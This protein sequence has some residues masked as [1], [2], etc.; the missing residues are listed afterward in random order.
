MRPPVPEPAPPASVRGGWLDPS[1][2]RRDLKGRL[3]GG[4]KPE[5]YDSLIGTWAEPGYRA[6]IPDDPG[7]VG[8]G[9]LTSSRWSWWRARTS[10]YATTVC[11]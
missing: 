6:D 9:G 8:G 2:V 5:D 7:M 3:P 4:K 10:R 1:Q 11:S